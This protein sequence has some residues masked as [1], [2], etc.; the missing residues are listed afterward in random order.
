[1]L[2][3]VAQRL[4][5]TLDT[6]GRDN[7]FVQLLG[8]AHGKADVVCISLTDTHCLG[9]VADV[10]DFKFRTLLR[11]QRKPS[12]NI[13]DSTALGTFQTDSSTDDRFSVLLL[14]NSYDFLLLAGVQRLLRNLC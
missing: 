13:C 14:Y 10:G 11:H 4:L 8:T 6:E 5:F 9:G 1:M 2:Y 7:H 3:I 12:V